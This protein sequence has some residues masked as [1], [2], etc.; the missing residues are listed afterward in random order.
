MS[1][2]QKSLSVSYQHESQNGSYKHE[3]QLRE[4]RV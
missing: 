4:C 1:Y 3:L 2:L